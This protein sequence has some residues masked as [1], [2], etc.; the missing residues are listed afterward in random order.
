MLAASP[1]ALP[2]ALLCLVLTL[3][4]SSTDARATPH[5]AAAPGVP[6][7]IMRRAN[8]QRSLE[9][10]GSWAQRNK[11]NTEAKY[12]MKSNK[13]KRANGM[14]LLTNFEFDS[15][16]FGSVAVGTPPTPF[17][18]ILDTGSSD[19]WLASGTGSDSRA[20]KDITLFEPTSSSSFTDLGKEFQIQYGSGSAQGV[21]GSDQVQFAGFQI[22]QTF[23]LVN[24]TTQSLL[25]A[26]MSGL[27]GLAFQSIAASGATPF[28]Q[29]LVETSGALDSPLFAF[30]LTRF[31]NDSS[32]QKT[33]PGG[34]FTL[35]A[36][37]NS[38]FTGDIDYQDIPNG[39]P[40]YWIQELSA[41]KVNGQSIS[42]PSGSAAWAAIDT[43]TTGVGC[44]SDVLASIFAAVPNS[45][46]GTGQFEGYYTFPC[47]TSVSLTVTWGSSSNA[48]TISPDDFILQEI[49]TQG[50]CVGA[51]FEVDSSGTTAPAFIFGDT[52][53]KNV[54]S[55]YRAS[56][57]SVGFATLSSTA[58]NANG[59]DAAAPS[60]TIGT[61]VTSVTPS[62]SG[63]SG[64]SGNSNTNGAQHGIQMSGAVLFSL[65]VGAACVLL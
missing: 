47:S 9:D 51:F 5:P 39:A 57:A 19:L 26:P 36:V 41:M 48:W 45:A 30:Q 40:G 18:V 64:T 61:G 58:I 23:G 1:T 60:A 52:F 32:A 8:V 3:A 12:G 22:G 31:T 63:S 53:L 15:T 27:M 4:P 54:Y 24:Q 28:W 25:T 6:I 62:T 38:L 17:D 20:T 33:E 7:N 29:S 56:P 13:G 46:P 49:D 50:T 44:P 16:Y 55:V 34:T 11:Q 10:L 35:G 43:G 42:L 14:N 37:N 59:V 21:L 2:L 65:L